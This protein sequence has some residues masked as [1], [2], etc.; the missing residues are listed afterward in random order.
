MCTVRYVK[1]GIVRERL[2]RIL[3]KRYLTDEA[4]TEERWQTQKRHYLADVD[5]ILNALS[6]P[7]EEMLKAGD[8]ALSLCWSLE[9]GE[10]L[11]DNPPE[12]IWQAMIKAAKEG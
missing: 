10:G 9:H 7:S 12:P 4:A 3:W 1:E 2:A 6:E 5:A 8:E 11:D